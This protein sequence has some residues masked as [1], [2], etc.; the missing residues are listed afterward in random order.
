MSKPKTS[1][2]RA[3]R[4]RTDN[5]L[6]THPAL[7]AERQR[8][9]AERDAQATS[10][11]GTPRSEAPIC[12]ASAKGTYTGLELLPY[13]GRANAMSAFALPTRVGNH[14]RYR[15]GHVT[16]LDGTAVDCPPLEPPHKKAVPEWTGAKTTRGDRPT[17]ALVEIL[18]APPGVAYRPKRD[19]YAGRAIEHLQA[20]GGT[21]MKKELMARFGLPAPSFVKAFEYCFHH[22]L[23]MRIMADRQVGV[24]LPKPVGRQRKAASAPANRGPR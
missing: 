8:M 23:L 2:A 13:A 1:A 11:N 6:A 3:D 18:D 21:L 20:N 10:S 15:D 16:E 7:H 19:S 22:G 17:P 24:A 5:L 12:N 4:A 14:L 9:F